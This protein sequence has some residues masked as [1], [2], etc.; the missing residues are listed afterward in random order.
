MQKYTD[1]QLVIARDAGGT[2]FPGLYHSP[3]CTFSLDG[4]VVGKRW[5]EM[6]PYA[7]NEDLLGTTNKPKP[8]PQVGEW[9]K[10]TDGE[11][12][13]VLVLLYDS[14]RKWV[15]ARGWVRDH[16]NFIPFCKM[17]EG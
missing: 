17:T 13:A 10:G 1:K 11:R 6:L 12:G 16:T 4:S 9:W 15:S 5:D 14:N 7:G 8:V 2:W 3:H